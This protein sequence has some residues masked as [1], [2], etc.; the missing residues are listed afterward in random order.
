MIDSTATGLT[1]YP[2][3]SLD[4]DEIRFISRVVA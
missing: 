3:Y 2:I 4:R 1:F